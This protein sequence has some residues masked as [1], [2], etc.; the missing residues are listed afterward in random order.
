LLRMKRQRRRSDVLY[1]LHQLIRKPMT[2][3]MLSID[4]RGT[5][6]HVQARRVLDIIQPEAERHGL[7]YQMLD[8]TTHNDLPGRRAILVAYCI[9]HE[10]AV[11]TGEL[12][13]ECQRVSARES[14]QWNG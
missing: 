5:W 3:D 1:C 12:C 6:S 9:E 13:A 2:T 7:F 4:P 14:W 10:I 8:T 11:V